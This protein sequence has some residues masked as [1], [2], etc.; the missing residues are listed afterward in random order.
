[1]DRPIKTLF[2]LLLLLHLCESGP[3]LQKAVL[4]SARVLLPSQQ[5][6]NFDAFLPYPDRAESHLSIYIFFN[7]SVLVEIYT[8]KD[9]FKDKLT[10]L[11]LNSMYSISS[12]ERSFSCFRE[13][14]KN[15]L[16]KQSGQETEQETSDDNSLIDVATS[17]EEEKSILILK[18][19]LQGACFEKRVNYWTYTF[20]PFSRVEQIHYEYGSRRSKHPKKATQTIKLGDYE[21][22]SSDFTT[23]FFSNGDDSREAIVHLVCPD[24]STPNKNNGEPGLLTKITENERHVYDITFETSLVCENSRN[25][26]ANNLPSTEAVQNLSQA[27]IDNKAIESLKSLNGQCG[28]HVSGWWTYEVCFSKEIRQFH[29]NADNS[30]DEFNLGKLRL[31]KENEPV[32]KYEVKDS[33]KFGRRVISQIFSQ[34]TECDVT[35]KRRETEV[36][37]KCQENSFLEVA[38]VEESVSCGYIVVVSVPKLCSFTGFS[39]RQAFLKEVENQKTLCFPKVSIDKILI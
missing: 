14:N 33:L 9:D 7:L 11:D 17:S 35:G 24:P 2:S 5:Q 21:Q 38:S 19:K 3:N 18:S 26:P 4:A 34:G 27:D 37:Y 25:L 20:C 15:A 29:K 12:P 8:S 23:Q 22:V 32:L 16:L 10:S 30:L 6:N 13:V 36:I 1:M 28:V 31:N 39:G